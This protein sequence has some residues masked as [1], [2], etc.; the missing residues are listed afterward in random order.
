MKNKMKTAEYFKDIHNLLRETL[1]TGANGC[2]MKSLDASLRRIIKLAVGLKGKNNKLIFIGNGGSAS[3]AS[4]MATDFLKNGG[5]PAV[6]F[7][8]A[9]LIT[10]LSNDLGYENVFKKPIEML[11]VKGDLLVSISSSGRSANILQATRAAREKSCFIITLSGF[12]SDNPLRKMGDINFYI[13]SRS[14]GYVE[15]AHSTI[16]HCLLDMITQKR[17]RWINTG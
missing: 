9:S 15:I 3:I 6:A 8:D 1:V 12:D 16:C 17:S 11:A 5:I 13:E 2:R 14:Y 7:N 10:C 4:H